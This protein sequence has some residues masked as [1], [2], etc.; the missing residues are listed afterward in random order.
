[1]SDEFFIYKTPSLITWFQEMTKAFDTLDNRFDNQDDW[2][3]RKMQIMRLF[4]FYTSKSHHIEKGLTARRFGNKTPGVE[5]YIE[6]YD[7][8][9]EK[10]PPLYI[11]VLRE[12]KKVF[13][14]TLNMDWGKNAHIKGQ[15]KRYLDS[16]AIIETYQQKH[17]GRVYILQ[18][19][20]IEPTYEARVWKR[21]K[22]YLLS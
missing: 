21:Q 22:S 2:G 15:L 19:D 17:L 16:I 10:N 13:L 5:H 1:M 8:I 4:W 3:T 20:K 7:N 11:Y 18:P 12:G 14:S 9:F 6:F